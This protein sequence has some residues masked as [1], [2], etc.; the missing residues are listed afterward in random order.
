MTQTRHHRRRQAGF[1]LIEV[2]V[3]LGIT[4]LF[5]AAFGEMIALATRSWDRGA[6]LVSASEITL[7]GVRQMARDLQGARVILIGG[8]ANPRVLFDGDS[9]VLRF[10]TAAENRANAKA[11]AIEIAIMADDGR[12]IIRRRSVGWGASN[13]DFASLAWRD[14]VI[15]MQGRY[16]AR[17]SFAKIS[18]N[19][20]IWRD[21]WAQESNLPRMVKLTLID[22]ASGQSAIGPIIVPLLT[23]A[24]PACVTEPRGADCPAAAPSPQAAANGQ[25]ST[26]SSNVR[27]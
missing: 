26:G 4:G 14:P 23:D 15:L 8:P 22:R 21:N 24:D 17:F 16:D 10:V 5:I 1:T 7:R 6:A 12:T 19:S 3:A 18:G 11:G 25:P 2:V 9:N 13:Y 20:V 27:P